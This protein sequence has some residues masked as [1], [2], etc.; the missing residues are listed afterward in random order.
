[1]QDEDDDIAARDG[2]G[3]RCV[4]LPECEALMFLVRNRDG[5]PGMSRRD[6]FK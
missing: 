5:I 3:R 4:P 2:L 1:M 6:V